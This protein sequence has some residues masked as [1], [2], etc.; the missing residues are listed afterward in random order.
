M[1]A[2][3]AR[4]KEWSA[5]RL[6][7]WHTLAVANALSGREGDATRAF[8]VTLS[9]SGNLEGRCAAA[10]DSLASYGERLRPPVDAMF[11]RMRAQGRGYD[12]PACSWPSNW[13]VRRLS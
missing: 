9:M 11:A 3:A 1:F 6:E 10:L 8:Y 4:G 12:S 7:D 5:T 2:L 13:S